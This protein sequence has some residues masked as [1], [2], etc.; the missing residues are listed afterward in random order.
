VIAAPSELSF[1]WLVAD[2]FPYLIPVA[3]FGGGL[4]LVAIGFLLPATRAA[5]NAAARDEG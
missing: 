2:P 5:R 1:L 3:R 4:W